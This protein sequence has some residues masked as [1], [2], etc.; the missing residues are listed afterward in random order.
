MRASLLAR[1]AASLP[2]AR[3]A[4][5]ALDGAGD[6]NRT[7]VAS[8][9]GWCS[10]IE[11]RPQGGPWLG[12]AGA[13]C[14]RARGPA[15]RGVVT[16]PRDLRQVAGHSPGVGPSRIQRA[17]LGRAQYGVTPLHYLTYGAS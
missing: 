13:C 4:G 8:L 10:A 1:V 7:R 17:R 6:G 12:R 3:K 11:P 14:C 5:W 16:F 2:A 15:H 9:E